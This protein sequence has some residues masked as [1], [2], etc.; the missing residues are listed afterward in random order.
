MR[1]ADS[2]L[3]WLVAAIAVSVQLATLAP[4]PDMLGD[5]WAAY[6][7]NAGAILSGG[8]YALPGYTANPLVDAGPGAY[9]PGLPLLLSV[10]IAFFG[11]LP[12]V[13]CVVNALTIGVFVRVFAAWLRPVAPVGVCAAAA[14][15][16]GVSP[17]FIAFHNV[18]ASEF[19]FVTLLFGWL[20]CERR[21]ESGAWR[22]GGAL[23]AGVVLG[24]ALLT[25]LA[26]L[27]A[28][29]G[30][31]LGDVLGRRGLRVRRVVEII[32][33]VGGLAVGL[34]LFAPGVVGHYG[35][36]VRAD[37]AADGGV[38]G[39][40]ARSV[41]SLPGRLS[42]LW[43]YGGQGP[44]PVVAAPLDWVRKAASLLLLLAGAGGLVLRLRQGA[45]AAEG[46]FIAGLLALLVLPPIMAGARLF[47]PL[48][49]LV[50]FFALDLAGR[51]R[52]A[53]AARWGVLAVWLLGSAVSWQAIAS[54]EANRF[55][56]DEA[57]AE[58]VFGWLRNVPEPGETVLARRAR[59]V[60]YMTGRA[61]TDWHQAHADHDFL[62]W[63]AQRNARYLMLSIDQ[64]EARGMAPGGG[65]DEAAL[66]AG[67]DAYEARF[68]GA[69]RGDF[70]LSF[71]NSRFRVYRIPPP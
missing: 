53:G 67:L 50:V 68:F 55:S 38:G 1:I 24:A 66:R 34:A 64:A 11:E 29:V 7:H 69:A 58:A 59:A 54:A 37:L 71:S 2:T 25:R 16:V 3:F 15:L 30:G 49:L 5:D 21:I 6:L 22:Y 39:M 23:V 17:F 9:P 18:V 8:A 4:T 33:A 14:L 27:P 10:P 70:E 13:A 60:A 44:Q 36:N 26:G 47:L 61:A 42:V 31:V 63:A 28:L 65:R 48:G 46:Y 19:L 45:G 62:T 52:W 12:V 43:A 20:L 41:L 32:V 51:V 56:V 35:A 57:R 40:L